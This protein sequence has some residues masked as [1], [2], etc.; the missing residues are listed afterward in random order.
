MAELSTTEVP[1]GRIVPAGPG[2]ICLHHASASMLGELM[3]DVG[4]LESSQMVACTRHGTC[5][6]SPGG[7]ITH[8]EI[9]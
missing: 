4:I 6:G 5:G 3:D 7:E 1:T 2:S 8:P 9:V